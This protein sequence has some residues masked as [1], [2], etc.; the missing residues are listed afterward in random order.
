MDYFE[1]HNNKKDLPR[2]DQTLLNYIY[3][4]KIGIL[5]QKY[6]MWPYINENVLVKEN[7]ILRNSI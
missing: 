4:D 2:H 3:H 6:H 1:T 5:P 7:K